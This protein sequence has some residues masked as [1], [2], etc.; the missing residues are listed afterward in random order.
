M[1]YMSTQIKNREEWQDW[2]EFVP[3]PTKAAEK[4]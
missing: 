4:I 3:F 2:D 1:G